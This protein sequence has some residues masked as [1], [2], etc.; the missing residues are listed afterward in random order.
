MQ[1]IK[2]AL[3]HGGFGELNG[4]RPGGGVFHKKEEYDEREDSCEIP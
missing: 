4:K 1:S 3:R 2:T